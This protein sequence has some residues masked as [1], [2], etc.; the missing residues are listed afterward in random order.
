[1]NGGT[2]NGINGF[3]NLRVKKYDA[4]NVSLLAW[5]N[6]ENE[7]VIDFYKKNGYIMTGENSQIYDDSIIIYDLYK[8]EKNI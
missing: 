8:F 6:N 3:S 2:H 4:N 7:K 5:Q 1:M